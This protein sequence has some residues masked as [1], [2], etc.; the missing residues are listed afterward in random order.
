MLR[1]CIG[2]VTR[3]SGRTGRAD[4]V[5]RVESVTECGRVRSFAVGGGQQEI[6]PDRCRDGTFCRLGAFVRVRQRQERSA[7]DMCMTQRRLT[8]V[9]II[10]LIAIAALSVAIG[11]TWNSVSAD[12]RPEQEDLPGEPVPEEFLK[13]LP[14]YALQFSPRLITYPDGDR[15][16]VYDR[17]AALKNYRGGPLP[18]CQPRD[19]SIPT[20][21]PTRE[22]LERGPTCLGLADMFVLGP[23]SPPGSAGP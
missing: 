21:N 15:V 4:A 6:C 20:R 9:S 11:L 2:A 18:V 17:E 8:M 16:I 5:H 12:S 7:G 23:P 1:R 13:F 3:R 14:E 22:D 10:G 19:S